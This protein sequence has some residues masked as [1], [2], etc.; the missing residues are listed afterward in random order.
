MVAVTQEGVGQWKG[1][2][3]NWLFCDFVFCYCPVLWPPC[4]GLISGESIKK[5]FG[6]LEVR[7]GVI[8]I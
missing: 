5:D 6:D 4:G 7:H 2:Q 3:K 1:V 8:T